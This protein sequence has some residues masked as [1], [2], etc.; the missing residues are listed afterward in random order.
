MKKIKDWFEEMEEP[1]RSLALKNTHVNMLEK[2]CFRF[3]HALC[4]AFVWGST[5]EGEDYWRLIRVKYK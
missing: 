3:N 5:D 4:G 2:E 1:E